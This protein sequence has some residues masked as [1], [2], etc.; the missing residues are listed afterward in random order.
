MEDKSMKNNIIKKLHD[1]TFCTPLILRLQ[2]LEV[3]NHYLALI[4]VLLSILFC[5]L[6]THVHEIVLSYQY[7]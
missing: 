2:Y 7:N 1:R 6:L 5:N 4:N 3:N